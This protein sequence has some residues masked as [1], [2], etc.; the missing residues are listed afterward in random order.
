MD[1]QSKPRYYPKMVGKR[2]YLSPMSVDDFQRYTTWLNDLEITRQLTF[3]SRVIGEEREREAIVEMSGSHNY[4]IVLRETDTLI[5]N[6]GIHDL[7]HLHGTGELGVM[8][9]AKELWGQGYGSEAIVLLLRYAFDYLNVRNVLLRVF[10]YNEHARRCYTR[11]GFQEIG[12]RR[13]AHRMEG[14]EHDVILMDMLDTE[15]RAR[16]GEGR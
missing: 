8:I 16:Y 15:F 6:V 3:A 11:V 4:G 7:D 14:H 13:S 10:S 9:G 2:V 12:R 5:G 1:A